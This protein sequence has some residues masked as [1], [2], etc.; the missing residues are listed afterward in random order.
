VAFQ[1][2]PAE[3]ADG[4]DLEARFRELTKGVVA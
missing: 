1:G 4:K 3:F 2:T